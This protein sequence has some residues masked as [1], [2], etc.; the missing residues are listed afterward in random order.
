MQN[1]K[2]QIQD[3]QY[4][5]MFFLL[6]NDSKTYSIIIIC[7]SMIPFYLNHVNCYLC[8]RLTLVEILENFFFI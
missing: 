5:I 7:Y 2:L 1:P 6:D 8:L 3:V 4:T